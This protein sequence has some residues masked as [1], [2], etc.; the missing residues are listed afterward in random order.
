MT[1][2]DFAIPTGAKK[3][4][5][6][7]VEAQ[8]ENKAEET[9]PTLT[10]EESEFIEK[11]FFEDDEKVRLRDGKSYY[12]PA[13]S[14]KDGRKLMKKLNSIDTSVIIAN[15]MEDEEGHDRF[16]DLMEV[17]LMAFKPYYPEM[18]VDYLAEYIDID[19]AKKIIDIMIGINGIKKSL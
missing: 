11:V 16:D 2:R 17:L 19:T 5:D 14:L 12:I 15:L 10:K 4:A 18:T 13:L 1:D 7:P 3:E 9:K 8:S 6:A